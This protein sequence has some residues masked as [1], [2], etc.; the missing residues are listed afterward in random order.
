M[1]RSIRRGQVGRGRSCSESET[2]RRSWRREGG[3]LV[4]F[5]G[6]RGSFGGVGGVLRARR[7]VVRA[8]VFVVVDET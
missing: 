5:D 2:S 7:R 6:E 3:V 8:R 1:V 4:S